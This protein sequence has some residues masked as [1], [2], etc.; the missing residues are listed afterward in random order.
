MVYV[1]DSHSGI[2]L[3]NRPFMHIKRVKD[4]CI[5]MRG[6]LRKVVRLLKNLR[7]D[8]T[9]E[10]NLSSYDITAIAWHMNEQELTVPFGM[11]LLLLD[12]TRLRLKYIID[13]ESYRSTLRVPDDSRM[14]FDKPDKLKPT[15]Q[16]YNELD[17]LTQDVYK[18][19]DPLWSLYKRPYSQVLSKAVAL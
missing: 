5:T 14:I 16:L 3:E 19:L 12:R 9:P 13:N 15:I 8:A 2:R 7:Y 17:Q 10:I 1:L 11:D 18:E 6:T 4:K